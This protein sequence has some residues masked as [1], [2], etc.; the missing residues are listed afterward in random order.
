MLP[1]F[2]WSLSKFRRCSGEQSPS[3]PELHRDIV[4]SNVSSFQA[5]R[6]ARLS[7]M[8]ESR[9][10]GEGSPTSCWQYT[11]SV[12]TACHTASPNYLDLNGLRVFLPR[13][14]QHPSPV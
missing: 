9:S 14:E 6:A 8:S 12:F 5:A 3:V 2:S 1:M 4:W 11:A 10:G 13:L 7:S